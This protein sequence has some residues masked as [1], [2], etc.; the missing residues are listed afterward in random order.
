MTTDELE[1][2]ISLPDFEQAA[3]AVLKPGAASYIAGGAGNETTMRDNLAAWDR[4]AL[5]PRVLRGGTPD[6][7]I[8]LL[9]RRRPHPVIVAPTAF[10]RLAHAEAEL[11]T[12]RAAAATDTVM[13]LSTFATTSPE[14]LAR[15]VPNVARWFQLY[16]LKDR[17][18]SDE[19][20]QRAAAN[21][22]EAVLV[23]VDLPI[24]S[25]RDRELRHPVS[26][27]ETAELERAA[28]L[29]GEAGITPVNVGADID[30]DL[31]WH[32]IERIAANSSM[33][34]IVKGILNA[35]DARLAAEHGAAG[36]VVSN[37]GG[38]QL[39]TVFSSADALPGIV[40]AVG[41][42]LEVLVD[43]GVRRGTDVVKALAIGARAV[44]VG[45]PVVC[46]L[47]VG[48]EAGARRVLELIIAEFETALKLSGASAASALDSS[49]ITR[50]PW[51]PPS[52]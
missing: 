38:R 35:D 30:A 12:A 21:G 32:D 2:L 18:I 29:V 15:E 25:T 1:S 41:D 34:V 23:T 46:G 51:A 5:I 36:I 31:S 44:L 26:D 14:T 10:Q 13:C 19:L 16:V 8:E 22:Y 50:A 39:D 40:D 45:R 43:G 52:R 48:G 47:A 24:M 42:S 49:Y 37:H 7:G 11:G 33:P 6:P 28:A 4:I 3:A 20:V 9:G 27:E 17:A